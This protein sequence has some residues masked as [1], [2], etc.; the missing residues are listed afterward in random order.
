M[1]E[2]D[3]EKKDPKNLRR[4]SMRTVLGDEWQQNRFLEL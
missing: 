1:K 3:E 2:P 4:P